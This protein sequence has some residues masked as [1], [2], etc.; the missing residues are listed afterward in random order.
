MFCDR[1]GAAVLPAQRFCGRCGKEFSGMVASG[2][3]Q[4]NRVQEHVHL[5]AIL[6]IVLSAM[7]A[8]VG[9]VML[10]LGTTL[11]PHLRQM[12]APPETPVGFLHSLFTALG[13]LILAKAAL[14][15]LAAWGLLRRE[16]WARVLTLVLAC[17]ALLEIPLGTALGVYSLWVLLPPQ[18][19]VEYEQAVHTAGMG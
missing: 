15:F 19:E 16:P 6:W 13:I 17:L 12:G 3:R 2:Y 5:L 1:C 10:V 9:I 14:G 4:P 11:F 18:S 8:L 7:H